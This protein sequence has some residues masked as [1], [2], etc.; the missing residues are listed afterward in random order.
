MG[1][2]LKEKAT[3]NICTASEGPEFNIVA[4]SPEEVKNERVYSMKTRRELLVHDS[5]TSN[6]VTQHKTISGD[7]P[8]QKL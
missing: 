2:I 5:T 3:Q 1:Q 6:S 7:V 4:A 8:A